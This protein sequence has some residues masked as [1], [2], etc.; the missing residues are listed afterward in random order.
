MAAAAGRVRAARHRRHRPF[1]WTVAGGW[2]GRWPVMAAGAGG[3]D[4]GE[5]ASAVVGGV[6]EL[7]LLALLLWRTPASAA[8]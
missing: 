3:V 1:N 6:D 4:D 7:E 8:A 5:D 2:F